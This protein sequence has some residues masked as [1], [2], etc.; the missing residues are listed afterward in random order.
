MK[1]SIKGMVKLG[2][3]LFAAAVFAAGCGGSDTG[4]LSLSLTDAATDQYN[5]VY[6]T[7]T[8][9][10]VHRNGGD[11]DGGWQTVATPNR[12][13]NLLDL[14]NG[15]REDLGLA[16]LDTGKYTQMRLIIGDTPDNGIN[17]LSQSHPFANYVIDT[18]NVIHELKVP[19]G[20]QTGIKIVQGFEINAN[21][22]TELILDFDAS[23]SV[24]IAGSSGQYLLKPTI[25]VLET[26]DF[27][28]VSGV[29]TSSVDG[30]LL[31]GVLVSAQI[32]TPGALDPK[33]EVVIQAAT[34]SDGL[35]NYRLFLK[36]GTYNLV[37]YKEGFSPA[38]VKIT[39]LAGSTPVQEFVLSP[40]AFGSV[41]GQVSITGATPETFVTLSFRQGVILNAVAEVIELTS[42]NVGNGGSYLQNLPVGP[43]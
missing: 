2:L 36:P 28:I 24:V 27:S 7:I 37:A 21:Q 14:V 1:N 12:T 31:P 34:V 41:Q 38:V 20:M 42:L 15:V 10:Q 16:T 35:G 29:V 6:V 40:T 30:S 11:P 43:A 23:A 25:K 33:D 18:D 5:A 26:T 22:T 13:F 9:V 39:T 32:F 8:E 4:Q 19:S 17:I 3:A